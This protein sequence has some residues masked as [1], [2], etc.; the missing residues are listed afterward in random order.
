MRSQ[1]RLHIILASLVTAI[2]F[3]TYWRTIAPTTSFWDCG[4]FIACSYILGVPHPPGAPLYLLVG[5]VF[6]MIPFAADIGLRVNMISAL[7]ST[8][9]VLFTY[10]II[11][12]LVQMWRGVPRSVKDKIIVYSS[13]VI[14]A[15]GFA[16]TDSHWFNAV[17][18]EVYSISLFFTA[19]VVW[20]IMVWHEKADNP[21]S[22]RYLLMI[23]YCVG[24]AL[25]VHLL[26]ILALPF[27]FLIFYFRKFKVPSV[28]EFLLHF[29][30][31]SAL[32]GFCVLLG[33]LFKAVV[34]GLVLYLAGHYFYYRNQR[35]EGSRRYSQL[36]LLIGSGVTIF[37]TIYPGVIKG[38]PYIAD[39]WS[40]SAL[41][42]V[43]LVLFCVM[44]FSIV[45]KER[46]ISLSL[47]SLFLIVLGY[48]TY[49]TIYIRSGMDPAIDE[50]DPETTERM[51]SYLNREQ[52]G[53]WGTLPR[54]FPDIP[55]EA[56]YEQQYPTKHYKFHEFGKQLSFFWNYQLNKMYWRYF[57]W[58]FIGKGTT[59]G[60]D[61]Y[62][63]ELISLRGLFA[64][65]FLIG[66]FGMV[67]HFFRDWKRAL[68]ILVLFV[69]TGIAIV[70]YLNQEDPQPR[71]RDY[72][73]TGSFFAFALWVGIGVAAVLE[74]LGDLFKSE[75]KR[76]RLVLLASSVI[77]FAIVPLNLFLFNYESHNRSGN[78]VAYDYSYN[79]LQ[80]CEKDAIVFTNGDNDTFPLWFLQEV[81]NVRKDVRVVNLSLLN[82]PWYI[83]QLR[84]HEP[85][86][87]IHMS[88]AEI[89]AMRPRPWKKT[90]VS[91]SVPPQARER[92]LLDLGERTQLMDIE[93]VDKISFEVAPTLMGQ[94]IRVQ[95]EMIL[96]ILEYNKWRRPIYF[97]VTVSNQNKINM[98]QFLR[99]D[100]LDFKIVTVGGQ[101]Q[102]SPERLHS[103]LF[104]VFRYRNLNNPDVYY[105]DNIKGLLQNYRAAFL[106][107]ASYYAEL[108]DKEK[109]QQVL[110]KVDE[111]LPESIIP[112]PDHR[113]SLHVG[114]LYR[115]SGR[116]E[117][118]ETRVKKLIEDH[119]DFSDAYR[120]LLHL[121]QT[122]N[123][124]EDAA[125]LL[126]KWVMQHP[127][128]NQAMSLINEYRE[129]AAQAADST[130]QNPDSIKML[131]DQK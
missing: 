63:V 101:Y 129:K 87:P 52:Y 20:L 72:V 31:A 103:T 33:M 86:V 39:K 62:I 88:D 42:G 97:A 77:L 57:G 89:D 48:S 131:P 82:T 128:D 126:Q 59:L 84:D 5:R 6:S 73:Y 47:M 113:A 28:V 121:Y 12:R 91:I 14:G 46:W 94:G 81:Y 127:G 104:E 96:R 125:D 70:V 120:N 4:E 75:E 95:D 19:A 65:P 100:G 83:K 114:Q 55:L 66:L 58:Q 111:V 118:F 74:W 68:P 67:H 43:V 9:T 36:A 40:L 93:S 115:A 98:Q 78:Y 41:A 123:R 45:K 49:A 110:D 2:A 112:I 34:L 116:I 26:N 7:A 92:D 37:A 13:G 23:A 71:E 16:F 15:L 56:V 24:L 85:R 102:I 44:V 11:V 17:E 117:A 1:R 51:V 119:P 21:S 29:M 61:R 25:A 124:Y 69:M 105:N 50:N 76:R 60:A 53:T 90:T 8:F 38:I 107:L 130:T 106:R 32:L 18:A 122:E 35:G 27:V 64:L 99:M 109:L 79:L 3:L 80:T 30:V 22:D 54:R 108:D 10:L